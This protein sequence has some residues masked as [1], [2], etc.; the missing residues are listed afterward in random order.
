VQ[1]EG[2]G[3]HIQSFTREST[4]DQQRH[5]QHPD[6][7]W[8]IKVMQRSSESV[9]MELATTPKI[10]FSSRKTERRKDEE[11]VPDGKE[12]LAVTGQSVTRQS[13]AC[14][15][16]NLSLLSASPSFD[17]IPGVDVIDTGPI[18]GAEGSRDAKR[19]AEQATSILSAYDRAEE[20]AP[21]SKSKGWFDD[22]FDPKV[23]LYVCRVAGM[24]KDRPR[25][26]DVPFLWVG[27]RN[28]QSLL[29]IWLLVAGSVSSRGLRGDA[30]RPGRAGH[31]FVCLH[32]NR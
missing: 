2:K 21:Q 9:S 3:G 19:A 29:A 15:C 26:P 13:L 25:D 11:C 16:S 20:G 8:D 5:E 4:K 12:Q 27:G 14:L 6:K 23:C 22:V 1:N 7:V 10:H 28:W 31:L 24:E 17:R 18:E 32:P 30:N